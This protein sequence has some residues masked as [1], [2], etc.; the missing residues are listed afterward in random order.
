MGFV[1]FLQGVLAAALPALF[2]FLPSYV[3]NVVPIFLAWSRFFG[4]ARFGAP[5]DGGR[6][7]GGERLFG[8]NKT[9][10]G[11]IGGALGGAL[12][13]LFQM[14]LY[15]W[16]PAWRGLYLFPYDSF[17]M[18]VALGFLM[19]LGEGLGDLLKSFTKRRLGV[20]NGKPFFPFD[21]LSFLGAL[22]L[23]FLV[24]VPE[25]N[26]VW[27][28]ILISPFIPIIAN[29]FGYFTGLKKVWW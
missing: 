13:T 8:A 27:A 2:Y 18:L 25:M 19:G 12:I 7:L 9:W 1:D 10:R 24:F 26:V 23:S 11:L 21:Q 4:A 17:W 5:I 15:A 16:I 3:G 28:I 14:G 22:L 6:R 20:G 29:I